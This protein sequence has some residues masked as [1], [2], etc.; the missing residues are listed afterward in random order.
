MKSIEYVKYAKLIRTLRTSAYEN[1]AIEKNDNFFNE[2]ESS[3]DHKI[4]PKKNNNNR[5]K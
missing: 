5:G 1:N 4:S 2:R 3:E